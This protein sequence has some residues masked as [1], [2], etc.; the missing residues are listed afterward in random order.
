MTIFQS[1]LLGVIQGL[2]EFL[3]ISSSG[4]LVIIPKL[5]GWQIPAQEAFVF[6]ILVQVATLLA[7]IA[8]FWQELIRIIYAFLNGLAHRTPFEDPFSRL[9]WYLILATIPAGIIGLAI[10]DLVEQAF[11]SLAAAGF[12]LLITAGLLLVAERLG[13]RSRKIDQLSR[14]DAIW[15]GLFQ[16]LAILPGISRS[17]ATMTGAMLRG[18]ERPSSAR[19]SFLMSIPIMLAAGLSASL[20]M[21]NTPDVL[22]SLPAFIPGFITAAVVGYISIRWLIGFL[23]HHPLTVFSSYC[24][25]VGTLAIVVSFF[26]K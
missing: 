15:I 4:H 9:G 10:K 22:S 17:G 16:A 1:I 19:F 20:D 5:L 18:L 12:F 13:N 21:V 8:Y 2:T 26:G 3:P 11:N 23:T 25:L 14:M 24:A 7:V 6:D